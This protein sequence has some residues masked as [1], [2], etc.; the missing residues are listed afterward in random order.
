MAITRRELLVGALAS[1]L[2]ACARPRSAL[3]VSPGK[4]VVVV[5]A[6]VSGLTAAYRLQARGFDVRVLEAQP[7]VGGRILTVREPF[8]DGLFVE[9][10][11][12]HVVSEP[13]FAAL[14][15]ELGVATEPAPHRPPPLPHVVLTGA[16]RRIAAAGEP[17]PSDA[18]L[19]AEERALDFTA[20]WRRYFGEPGDPRAAAWLTPERAKLDR[21][22]FGAYLAGLGA[23]PAMIES[24]RESIAMMEPPDGVSAL[25]VTEQAAAIQEEMTWK[26]DG[27]IVGGT[28]QLP[29]AL[30]ARLGGRITLGAVVRRI[31]EVGRELRV[32]FVRGGEPAELVADHVVLAVHAPVVQRIAIDPALPEAVTRALAA[33][34]IS[35]VVRGWAQ[36][37]RRVWQ[38]AGV[39][40]NAESD[41]LLGSLHDETAG[42]AGTSGILSIYVSS[43][44]ARQVTALAAER[45]QAELDAL[46]TRAHPGAR[47][48]AG[49][50]KAWDEDPWAGGAYSYLAPGFMTEHL[51]VLNRPAGRL[52]FAGDY[53]SYR[54]GFMHGAVA[55]AER[56]VAEIAGG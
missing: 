47:V 45:R 33:V 41:G 54:V 20:R 10:G 21:L 11:A 56:V 22:G 53:T 13:G 8:R 18:G 28:D 35:S 16:T 32:G 2:A 44:A 12:K 15:R 6:G 49:L 3:P 39:A 50:I 38:D 17:D 1:G 24:V 31:R 37:E 36:V 51:P 30:A 52:H 29:R 7:R 34:R 27:R 4:R 14:L 9:A 55:S 26:G 46:V 42:V 43:G 25:W 23:S 40:G 19:T 5:G 48:V